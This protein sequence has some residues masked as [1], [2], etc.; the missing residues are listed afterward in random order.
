MRKTVLLATAASLSL[1]PLGCAPAPARHAVAC[2]P[3][4]PVPGYRTCAVAEP[5]FSYATLPAGVRVEALDTT[6]PAR[7]D[8]RE[9]PALA[10]C[11]VV[12][13]QGASGWCQTVSTTT[14]LEATECVACEA[15]RALDPSLGIPRVSILHTRWM[16]FHD[17]HH[18]FVQDDLSSGTTILNAAAVLTSEGATGEDELPSAFALLTINDAIGDT[19]P[20]DYPIEHRAATLTVLAPGGSLVDGLRHALAER[21]VPVIGVPYL[22]HVGWSSCDASPSHIAVPPGTPIPLSEVPTCGG[23]EC[24]REPACIV[25]TSDGD[26]FHAVAIVGYDDEAGAFV[27]QNSWGIGWGAGGFGTISYEYVTRWARYALTLDGM[28]PSVAGA[29]VPSTPHVDRCAIHTSTCGACT[30]DPGCGWCA[31]AGT[32]MEAVEGQSQPRHGDCGE[33]YG[34]QLACTSPALGHLP[35]PS[36]GC[37]A[38]VRVEGCGWAAEVDHCFPIDDV[39]SGVGDLSRACMP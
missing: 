31:D 12:E 19:V 15:A 10:D 34:T 30:A 18:P 9:D 17:G 26:S 32:C 1:S 11:L 6:L 21:R 4:E 38:C 33:W 14:A 36:G 7:V 24:D 2:I 16:T 28:H 27:L 35:C 22:H 39:P 13:D 8:L 23:E 37:D 5:P 25:R 29:C 3:I 20:G